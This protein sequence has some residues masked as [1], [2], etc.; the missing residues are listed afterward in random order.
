M[1]GK[2]TATRVFPAAAFHCSTACVH[3]KK[4]MLS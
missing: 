2:D 4:L 3:K 1:K